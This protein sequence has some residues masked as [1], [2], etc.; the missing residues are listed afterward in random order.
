ISTHSCG[1]CGV[2][3]RRGRGMHRGEAR[4]RGRFRQTPN[5]DFNTTCWRCGKEGHFARDCKRQRTLDT[6]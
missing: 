2:S 1:I 6:E 3:Q 4:G 5:S